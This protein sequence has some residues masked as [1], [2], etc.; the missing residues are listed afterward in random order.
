MA[1]HIGYETVV[2][3]ALTRTDTLAIKTIA[4]QAGMDLHNCFFR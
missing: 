3:F 2:P 1:L 4:I